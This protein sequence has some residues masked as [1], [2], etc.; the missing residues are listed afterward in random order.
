MARTSGRGGS[1]NQVLT[2]GPYIEVLYIAVL[3]MSTTGGQPRRKVIHNFVALRST[4][5]GLHCRGER[6]L[7]HGNSGGIT[8]RLS[9]SDKAPIV[10]AAGAPGKQG[11]KVSAHPFVLLRDVLG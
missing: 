2:S 11:D 9:G 5:V 7:P 8:I 3:C 6:R 10:D 1:S 4:L